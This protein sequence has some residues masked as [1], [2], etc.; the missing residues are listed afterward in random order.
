[1]KTRAI[2]R[3]NLLTKEFLFSIMISILLNVSEC[4]ETFS[5]GSLL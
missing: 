5:C 4:Y 1:M 2:H 3:E